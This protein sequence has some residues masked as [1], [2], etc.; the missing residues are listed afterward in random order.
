MPAD[1]IFNIKSAEI[2]GSI[3]LVIY[4]EKGMSKQNL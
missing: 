2:K 4:E 1:L 3:N